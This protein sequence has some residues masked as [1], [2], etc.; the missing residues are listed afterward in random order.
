M[1]SNIP[2]KT[3]MP[4]PWRIERTNAPIAD[5]GDYDCL[6]TVYAADDE[7]V[8]QVWNASDEQEEAYQRI[9]SVMNAVETTTVTPEFV[10]G[11][12]RGIVDA[13]LKELDAFAQDRNIQ[14]WYG[15]E[16]ALEEIRA[17]LDI[18]R[19]AL[20]A[21]EP[22]PVHQEI[23]AANE[24]LRRHVHEQLGFLTTDD[25]RPAEGL[26]RLAVKRLNPEKTSD[27]TSESMAGKYECSCGKK[28]LTIEVFEHHA[29]HC[30]SEN[31]G[32]GHE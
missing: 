6:T 29:E 8:F 18:A 4:T 26:I 11:F 9:V 21:V 16:F 7:D 31:G 5:T 27:E 30:P 15:F 28:F 2:S 14:F 1:T 24:A 25:N 3:V 19:K 22:S 13:V 20:P 17:R 23:T 10:A 12:E 32:A